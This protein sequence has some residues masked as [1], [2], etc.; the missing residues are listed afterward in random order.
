LAVYQKSTNRKEHKRG[1]KLDENHK[2]NP[3]GGPGIPPLT[4]I[5]TPGD[6]DWMGLVW[7]GIRPLDGETINLVPPGAGLYLL[8]EHY[9]GELVSI[10]QSADCAQRLRS[11]AMK[12]LDEKD[13]LF[14]SCIIE[15]AVLPHNLKELENDLIGNY[16]ELCRKAPKYQFGNSQ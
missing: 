14:S 10:G 8:F 7:S 5:G 2:D 13:L 9:T 15:K 12:F 3:A 16:F 4:I 6:R 1:G 11:H